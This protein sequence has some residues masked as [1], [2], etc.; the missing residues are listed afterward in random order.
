MA[1]SVPLSLL[2]GHGGRAGSPP[3]SAFR[4]LSGVAHHHFQVG[5][6]QKTLAFGLMLAT[7]LVA[8]F[9]TLVYIGVT[10]SGYS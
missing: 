3:S 6:V 1:I 7:L 10:S 2:D 5:R 9:T 8:F 4:D